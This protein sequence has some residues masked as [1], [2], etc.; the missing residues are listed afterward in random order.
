MKLKFL[1]KKNATFL[2][3]AGVGFAAATAAT[4]S[5]MIPKISE[6][7]Q[8]LAEAG[9]KFL[10]GAYLYK[11]GKPGSLMAG[12]GVGVAVSG[13]NDAYQYYDVQQKLKDLEKDGGAPGTGRQDP[14]VAMQDHSVA[15][16]GSYVQDENDLY[17]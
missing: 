4:E 15:G 12:A 2:V 3:G 8:D 9:L 13:L 7:H 14:A 6:E 11:K 1:D 5:G 16:G 17:N 10:A